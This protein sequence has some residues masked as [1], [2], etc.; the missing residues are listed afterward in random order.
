MRLSRE[1][2]GAAAVISLSRVRLSRERGGS[3]A[4]TRLS[5]VR[6]SRK[7]GR[8]VRGLFSRTLILFHVLPSDFV[9]YSVDK[10]QGRALAPLR[11]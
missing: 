11:Y 6:L 9:T 7:K 1:G 10:M 2:G 8:R 5:R 3:V 4:V